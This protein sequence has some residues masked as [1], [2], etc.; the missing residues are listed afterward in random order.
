MLGACNTVW[1]GNVWYSALSQALI[2]CR[3]VCQKAGIC[4]WDD[5]L[6]QTPTAGVAT[7]PKPTPSMATMAV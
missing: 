7:P 2:F 1:N 6:D 3:K 4:T 5:I